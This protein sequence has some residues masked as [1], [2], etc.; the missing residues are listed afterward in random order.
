MQSLHGDGGSK[1]IRE[2]AQEKLGSFAEDSEN[3]S[4]GGKY[5]PL[6]VWRQK[7]FDDVA[8]ARES[9]ACDRM[10]HKILGDVYRVRIISKSHSKKRATRRGTQLTV[11]KPSEGEDNSQMPRSLAQPLENNDDHNE[12]SDG[13]SSESSDSESDSSSSPKRGKKKH[14]K[15][16]KDK[17]KAAK[18]KKSKKSKKSKKGKKDKHASSDE[19]AGERKLRLRLEAKRTAEL[20]KLGEAVVKTLTPSKHKIQDLLETADFETL[21]DCTKVQIKTAEADIMEALSQGEAA[22]SSNSSSS[23]R[24]SLDVSM[25]DCKKLVAKVKQHLATAE[26]LLKTLRRSK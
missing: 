9:E 16:K 6:S 24:R 5:L 11:T 20:M 19:T 14:R 3:F 22:R 23:T 25:D 15:S 4:E 8:I 2:L 26:T 1:R 7:G 18:K 10:H 13:E 21:P 17:R 12:S